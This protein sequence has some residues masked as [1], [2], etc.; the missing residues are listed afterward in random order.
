MKG[1]QRLDVQLTLIFVAILSMAVSITGWIHQRGHLINLIGPFFELEDHLKVIEPQLRTYEQD[2]QRPSLQAFLHGLEETSEELMYLVVNEGFHVV[3]QTTPEGSMIELVRR[4]PEYE[5]FVVE[6]SSIEERFDFILIYQMVPALAFT[7]ANDLSFHLIAIPKPRLVDAPVLKPILFE[8]LRHHFDIFGWFYGF[9]ILFFVLFIR[10]RLRPLRMIESASHRLTQREIPEPIA[11][12]TRNDEVGQLVS[13]FNH[14]LTKLAAQEQTR[15]R[16]VADIAHELRTP[17]TN[18]SGRIEAF[19]DGILHNAEELIDFTANQVMSLTRIV[20]DLSL[21]SRGD[22]GELT[23]VPESLDVK[24][25][26][27]N[28]L[29]ENNIGDRYRWQV[30]GAPGDIDVDPHRFH[31]IF[32]NLI[33]NATQEKPEDL[34]ITVHIHHDQNHTNIHFEDNGPGVSNRHLPHLFERLYRVSNHRDSQSGGSGLGLSIV[35]TLVEAHHGRVRH[36]H[37]P[38][39]GLGIELTFPRRNTLS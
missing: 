15:K 36:Y 2:E 37:V 7:G 16:M 19:Q 31:Q 13:A 33:A 17:L 32:T 6:T 9:V 21:L 1:L 24:D 34:E 25:S 14:A 29:D 27:E 5:F 4:E 22:A 35:K 8:G 18:L 30:K 10:W 20:E 3:A 26:L 12:K 23:M 39:G 11:V 38:S 28:I